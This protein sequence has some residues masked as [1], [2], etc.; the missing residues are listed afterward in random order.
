[1]LGPITARFASCIHST[2]HLDRSGIV[3]HNGGMDYPH[4]RLTRW[5]FPTVPEPAFCDF[6]ADR[7]QLGEDIEKLLSTLS[8]Q[9]TSSIHLVWSWFGAGK[10][11]TLYYFVSQANSTAPDQRKLHAVYSEFPKAAKSFVDL[12]RSFA[13]GLDFDEVIE[14]Y[15]EISTRD[16][17]NN[18]LQAG[19]SLTGVVLGALNCLMAPWWELFSAYNR[20]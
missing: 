12:Y 8:R 4:L 16:A 19:P 9:N 7:K 1:M 5:P 11:H 10:T 6:I 17:L 14:A 18:R 3:S 13:A 20:P 2:S 15:L